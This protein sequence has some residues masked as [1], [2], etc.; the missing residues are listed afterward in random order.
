MESSIILL[1]A[2]AVG[3]VIYIVDAL[4][5]MLNIP[6]RYVPL[7]PF[8]VAAPI[9]FAVVYI[10]E[11]MQG[12][13]HFIVSSMWEGVKIAALAMSTYKITH[14]TVLNGGAANVQESVGVD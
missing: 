10:R 11:G 9:G 5:K 8:A 1:D 2:S 4:R 7:I 12:I 14:T 13:P 3:V 6:E